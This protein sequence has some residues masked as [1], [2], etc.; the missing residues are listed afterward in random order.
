MPNLKLSEREKGYLIACRDWEMQANYFDE[1]LASDENVWFGY[2]IGGRKLDMR[3]H[4]DADTDEIIGTVF[5]CLENGEPNMKKF[6]IVE[7]MKGGTDA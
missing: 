3:L 6:W 5:D 2:S 7:R 1:S 4:R